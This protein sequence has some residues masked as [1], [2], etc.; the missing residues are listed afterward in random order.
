MYKILLLIIFFST[1]QVV[2]VFAQELPDSFALFDEKE[3]LKHVES[4]SSDVFEGR[5]TGTNGASKTRKYIINQ[6][7]TLKV[8]SLGESFEQHFVFVNNRKQYNAT[9]IL[10][11]IKG[12]TFPEKYIV[13]SAHYDHEGVKYGKIYNGADDNASGVGALFAFAEYLKNKSPKHSVILA[14]FDGE[15]LGLQGSKYFVENSIIQFQDIIVN[16][17]M[18]MISRSDKKEL[19]VVGTSENNKLKSLVLDSKR[20]NKIKLVTGH[21]GYD[22]LDN[23][24]YSSDHANFY[25]KGVPFLYFGVE[26][27][28]DYHEPTDDYENIHPEFYTEAVKTIISVFEKIDHSKL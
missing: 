3:L 9:N 2:D 25:K 16:L 15:E 6:F 4:L 8:K 10:G 1:L 26:D 28:K 23:W 19:Y 18:D 7:H 21:D 17:N 24:T 11:R 20:Q 12:T 5:R 14:A 22:G 13:I 27:H